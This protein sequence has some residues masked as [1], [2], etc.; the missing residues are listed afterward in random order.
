MSDL[1]H[2]SEQLASAVEHLLSKAPSADFKR[3]W[4]LYNETAFIPDPKGVYFRVS[5][6]ATYRNL[7][8]AGKTGIV[9]IEAAESSVDSGLWFTRYSAL[10]GVILRTGII[11][12]L[13]HT[14][15]SLLTVVCRISGTSSLGH[16]WCAQDEEEVTR[17]RSFARILI[18][19]VSLT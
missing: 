1:H 18:N 15:D 17:L 14:E 2:D 8:I 11:P 6:D 4:E 3:Y 19:E 9:D 13:P 5:N 7:V 10:S 12:S 16:Y